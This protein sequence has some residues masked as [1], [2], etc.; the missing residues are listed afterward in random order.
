MNCTICHS[1]NDADALFCGECGQPLF[2]HSLKRDKIITSPVAKWL[3]QPF[4]VGFTLFCSALLAAM[5]FLIYERTRAVAYVNS[6]KISSSQWQSEV[7]LNRT[8]IEAQYGPQIFQGPQGPENYRGFR[9][10]VLQTIII[11]RLLRQEAKRLG[12]T[13]APQEVQV[14]LT[15]IIGSSNHNPEDFLKQQ[16]LSRSQAIQILQRELVEEKLLNSQL[17]GQGQWISN[18]QLYQQ[19]KQIYLGNLWARAQIRF[20]DKKFTSSAKKASGGCSCCSQKNEGANAGAGSC[21]S[22]TKSA[23]PLDPKIE[24][25]A[26]EAALKAYREKY[27]AGMVSAVVADYGCHIQMDIVEKGKILKSYA[28]REGQ[29]SEIN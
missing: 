16:G 22:G 8:K 26:R 24:Q 4:W 27:G 17:A 29:A 13:V 10:Q 5:A 1:P 6:E 11:D 3:R 21:G 9:Y 7:D 14:R 2:E 23:R 28:Y 12:I 25:A 15:T 18:P 19:A 20:T